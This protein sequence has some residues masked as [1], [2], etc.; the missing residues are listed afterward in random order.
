MNVPLRRETNLWQHFYNSSFP[1]LSDEWKASANSESCKGS[2]F[3]REISVMKDM[4]RLAS[5]HFGVYFYRQNHIVLDEKISVARFL[6]ER[7][8]LS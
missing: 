7:H 4:M 6:E 8:P 5:S 2:Q 3:L 1:G